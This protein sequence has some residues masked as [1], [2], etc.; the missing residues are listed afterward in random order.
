LKVV[1]KVVKNIQVENVNPHIDPIQNVTN[2]LEAEERD[3]DEQIAKVEA[4]ELVRKR[5]EEK[6][7]KLRKLCAPA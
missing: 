5:V 2:Q 4:M 3:L 7:E 6:R 1:K